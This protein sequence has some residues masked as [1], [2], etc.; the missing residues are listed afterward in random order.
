MLRSASEYDHYGYDEEYNYHHDPINHYTVHCC[1]PVIDKKTYVAFLGF[2][3]AATWFLWLLIDKSELMAPM[4][5]RKKRDTLR[6]TLTLGRSFP[7]WAR[8][9]DTHFIPRF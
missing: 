7:H 9:S 6:D 3:A 2:L 8:E 4:M 1:E 5:G